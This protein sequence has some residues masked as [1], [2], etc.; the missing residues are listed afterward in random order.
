M[1]ATVSSRFSKF[2]PFLATC[3]KRALNSIPWLVTWFT[4]A[5]RSTRTLASLAASLATSSKVSSDDAM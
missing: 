3:S 1:R 2:T 4:N 5:L